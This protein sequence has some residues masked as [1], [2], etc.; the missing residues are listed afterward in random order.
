MFPKNELAVF[1]AKIMLHWL[2]SVRHRCNRGNASLF[3]EI[4]KLLHQE[5]VGDA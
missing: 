2:N 4:Q 1:R 5:P 3:Q